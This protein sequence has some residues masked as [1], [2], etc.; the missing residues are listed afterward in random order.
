MGSVRLSAEGGIGRGLSPAIW[1]A[2]KFI[3]GNYGD[4]SL[5]PMCFEDFA[6]FGVYA[7]ATSQGGFITYQDTGVTI[8]P[9]ADA[10]N[11]EGEFGVA[12]IA[13]NDADNDEGHL[14]LGAGTSG[15]VRIDP[16]SGERAV[17]A[18]EARIK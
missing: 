3:G 6:N 10:D 15:L 2:Y 9:A 13:N 18:M 11:S 8:Q 4:P 12:E 7:T 5:H 17:V 14:E 16:T 1:Q